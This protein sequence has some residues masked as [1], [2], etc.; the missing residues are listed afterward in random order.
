[1]LYT[2]VDDD[3]EDLPLS[4]DQSWSGFSIGMVHKF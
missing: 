2:N 1:M 4:F 3:R